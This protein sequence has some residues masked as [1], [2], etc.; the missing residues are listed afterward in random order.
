MGPL[1]GVGELAR[2][3]MKT[4]QLEDRIVVGP[5]VRGLA[6]VDGTLLV[7]QHRSGEEGGRW[8][9]VDGNEVSAY[10]L[11]WDPGPDSDGDTRG[12]PSYLQQVVVRPDGRAAVFPGLKAN[13]QR[14]LYLEGTP[15]T[16]ET[17]VRADLRSVALTESA[18]Y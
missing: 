13:V 2:F 18:R 3:S 1:Q 12:I 10:L 9:V 6:W 14:G 17:S 8:Y 4:R 16:E 15:F 7:S 5:D 11:A